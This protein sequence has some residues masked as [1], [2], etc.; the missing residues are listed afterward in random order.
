M[1]QMA[2]VLPLF[3]S[4]LCLPVLFYRQKFPRWAIGFGFL[5][6]VTTAFTALARIFDG[7]GASPASVGA[8]M[9]AA[10]LFAL[11]TVPVRPVAAEGGS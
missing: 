8:W 2:L 7:P 1:E 3:V 9:L 11:A 4:E 10:S 5:P 6:A